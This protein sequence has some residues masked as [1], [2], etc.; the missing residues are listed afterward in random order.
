[1]SHALLAH[2]N[3][4]KLHRVVLLMLARILRTRFALRLPYR[5]RETYGH[6]YRKLVLQQF[7]L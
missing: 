7:G 6:F 4:Y 3:F 5:G 2:G 1:V